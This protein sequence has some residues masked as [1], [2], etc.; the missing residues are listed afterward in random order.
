MSASIPNAQQTVTGSNNIFSG[1][2]DVYY[3]TQ[4]IPIPIAEIQTRKDLLTLLRRVKTF[5]IDDVLNKSVFNAALIDLGKEKQAEA[6]EHPWHSVLEQPDSVS[7]TLARGTSMGD[8]FEQANG[9]LLIL[10]DPGSGKTTTLLELARYLII[11]AENDKD[12]SQPVPVIFNLS[13]WKGQQLPLIDWMIAE[14]EAKYKIPNRLTRPW[15]ENNRLLPLL[16]GLDEV[17]SEHR[18]ACVGAIN[19]FE[20]EFG[21]AGLVVCCR[22]EEYTSLPVRLR[23]NSAISLQPLTPEHV[24][25]Y[26]AAAGPKLNG[27]HAAL[28]EDNELLILA[29]SPLIL[30][31]MTLAYQDV[32]VDKLTSPT[33]NTVEERRS[34]LFDTYIERMFKRHGSGNQLYSPEQTKDWLAWLAKRMVQNKQNIFLIE[35]LQP[36]W[37]TDRNT[38]R[39]YVIV[40]RI[41]I[42]MSF[43]I[44]HQL[45]G[46]LVGIGVGLFDTGL[47]LKKIC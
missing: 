11:R 27:L 35:E 23:L 41:V 33:S 8:I 19:N 22:R 4:P 43:M 26:L 30:S 40:S 39:L 12:F 2:G 38:R 44:G 13:T 14:L 31:I 10:G 34:H 3:V 24:N 32:S 20:K 15:L 47:S 5:W 46:L 25:E 9:A 17:M 1:T 42:V 16:D 7:H 6:V 37:L 28:S 45:E 21:L 36:I 18:A 29:Q